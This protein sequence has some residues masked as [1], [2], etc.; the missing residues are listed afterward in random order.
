LQGRASIGITGGT[1]TPEDDL[2]TVRE[3]VL[4]LA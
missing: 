1:S 4:A 3:R 2:E